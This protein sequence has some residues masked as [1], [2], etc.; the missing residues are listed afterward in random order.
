MPP[1]RRLAAYYTRHA[2]EERDHDAWLLDDMAAS[3]E[4]R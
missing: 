1:S 2:E 4:S 3:Y